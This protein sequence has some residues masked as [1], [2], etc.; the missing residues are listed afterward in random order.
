MRREIGTIESNLVLGSACNGGF[1]EALALTLVLASVVC[2]ADN[3]GL[4]L[5]QIHHL[6]AP[7]VLHVEKLTQDNAW[8]GLH[9][10]PAS[11]AVQVSPASRKIY[12]R[13]QHDVAQY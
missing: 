7:A 4:S 1:T 5:M 10:T 13:T 2:A 11:S 12:P 9:Q 3:L 6:A 8:A